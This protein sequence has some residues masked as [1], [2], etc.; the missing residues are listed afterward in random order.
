MDLEVVEEEMTMIQTQGIVI[1]T[2]ILIEGLLISLEGAL[3]E[4]IHLE[5]GFPIQVEILHQ[6]T[7]FLDL[8]PGGT[9]EF[10]IL[11]FQGGLEVPQDRSGP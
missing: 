4:M 2:G 11:G 8:I 5:E 1:M 9:Q 6:E 10:H 7:I 3:E